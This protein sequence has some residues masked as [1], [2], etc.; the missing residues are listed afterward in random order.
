MRNFFKLFS[1]YFKRFI[2]L[3]YLGVMLGLLVVFLYS[4]HLGLKEHKNI[5]YNNKELKKIELLRQKV[6][7]SYME[8]SIRGFKI[9]YESPRSGIFFNCPVKLS[10]LSGKVNSIITLDIVGNCKGGQIFRGNSRFSFRFSNVVEIL[11]TLALLLFG[12]D[13]VR[14]REYLKFL[15]GNWTQGKV[16]ASIIGSGIIIFL[17]FM[18]FIIGCCLGLC[19]LQGISLTANDINGFALSLA[20]MILMMVSSFTAGIALGCLKSKGLGIGLLL[21]IWIGFVLILPSAADSIIE[22]KSFE[23]SSPYKLKSKKLK[24]VNDF[25]K[26]TEKKYGKFDK[27]NMETERII[28]EDY[29]KEIFPLLEKLDTRLKSEISGLTK[30][31][32]H[33]SMWLPTTFYHSVCYEVSGRGYYNYLSFYSYLQSLYRGFVRF[34]IDRVYYHDPKVLVNFIQADENIFHGKSMIPPNYLQ[35]VTVNSG[36]TMVLLIITYFLFF[37]RMLNHMKKS[38]IAEIDS[39]LK[40]EPLALEKGN[41]RVILTEGDKFPR[42]L[43]T[44]F[45]GEIKILHRKGFSQKVLLDGKDISKVKNKEGIFYI[46]NPGSFPGDFKVIDFINFFARW[47]RVSKSEKKAL[48]EDENIKPLVHKRIKELKNHETFE[49][50]Y[51]FLKMKQEKSYV[52]LIDDTTVVLPGTCLIRLKELFDRLKQDAVV[53]YLTLPQIVG[54][55]RFKSGRCFVDGEVWFELVEKIKKEFKFRKKMEL[56]KEE[57]SERR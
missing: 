31:Y 20:P 2:S 40:K 52:Y 13:L 53:I 34:W 21:L 54:I 33:V 30:K 43:Y 12:F 15:S 27:N 38:E 41:L 51:L 35:G 42:F 24:M 8:Y 45:S 9:F 44:L 3:R 7:K 22:D 18:A 5:K 37:K 36:W 26:Y 11:V 48:L 17:V 14:T 10:D 28:V 39:G 4:T 57:K 55:E 25:E 47:N 50:F 16:F 46:S 19:Q 56:E 1:L 6:M 29:L 32:H 23:I 49:I